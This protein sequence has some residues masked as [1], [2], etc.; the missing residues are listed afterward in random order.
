MSP[1]LNAL[2]LWLTPIMSAQPV[3]WL[4]L[5]TSARGKKKHYKR[6][7]VKAGNVSVVNKANSQE[8]PVLVA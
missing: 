6:R 3:L 1:P 8:E 5:Q 2:F 4:I 7:P